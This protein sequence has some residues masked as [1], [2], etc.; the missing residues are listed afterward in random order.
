MACAPWRPSVRRRQLRCLLIRVR[1]RTVVR[2]QSRLVPRQPRLARSIQRRLRRWCVRDFGLFGHIPPRAPV[3]NLLRG[4]RKT[5]AGRS[6]RGPPRHPRRTATG[7]PRPTCACSPT[8]STATATA[9]GRSS[10]PCAALQW[11]ASKF[12]SKNALSLLRFLGKPRSLSADSIVT[13]CSL[14]FEI[15]C[16]VTLDGQNLLPVIGRENP[17]WRGG[18]RPRGE[19]YRRW[20]CRSVGPFFAQENILVGTLFSPIPRRADPRGRGPEDRQRLRAESVDAT[21]SE[22]VDAKVEPGASRDLKNQQGTE[23]PSS[24]NICGDGRD[25]PHVCSR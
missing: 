15:I 5:I 9:L 14:R 25:E 24:N 3:E 4:R 6:A 19:A 11:G 1:C 2:G 13:N 8:Q 16:R 17:A 22:S 20:V 18:G 12:A 21:D 10:A 7:H 23:E